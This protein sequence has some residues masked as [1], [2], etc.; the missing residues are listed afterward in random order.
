VPRNVRNPNTGEVETRLV[1]KPAPKYLRAKTTAGERTD[2][3]I[4]RLTARYKMAR[5]GFRF[6]PADD[7]AEWER[8][9][10]ISYAE[11]QIARFKAKLARYQ[12]Q[13]NPRPEQVQVLKD[14]INRYRGQWFELIGAAAVPGAD[15]R[16]II[17]KER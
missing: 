10:D 6:A 3:E 14:T 17:G 7:K 12:A 9:R 2:H 5:E 8:R 1:R 16:A 11:M 13:P 15:V 4:A